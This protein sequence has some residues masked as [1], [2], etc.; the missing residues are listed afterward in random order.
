LVTS[1]IA[2]CATSPPTNAAVVGSVPKA[3][4]TL[5]DQHRSH[6][7][8]K[9]AHTSAIPSVTSSGSGSE[10]FPMDA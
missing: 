6:A 9:A 4:R 1:L 10:L 7:A 2:S 3:P 8:R 5:Q